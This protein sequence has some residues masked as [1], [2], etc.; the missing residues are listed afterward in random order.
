MTVYH[1]W[2]LHC[3]VEVGKDSSTGVGKDSGMESIRTQGMVLD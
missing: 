2:A 1:T 3:V